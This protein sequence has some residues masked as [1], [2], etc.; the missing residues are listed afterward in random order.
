M[1]IEIHPFFGVI[2]VKIGGII[3]LWIMAIDIKK[4]IIIHF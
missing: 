4:L 3:L 2:K 1:V